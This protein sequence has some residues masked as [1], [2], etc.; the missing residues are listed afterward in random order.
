LTTK[1]S[2]EN[3]IKTRFSNVILDVKVMNNVEFQDSYI[4]YFYNLGLTDPRLESR[5]LFNQVEFSDACSF[6]NVYGFVVPRSISNNLNYLNISQ[7]TAIVDDINEEKI[8]TSAFIP[9]DPVFLLFDIAVPSETMTV[10]NIANTKLVIVKDTISR[11]N[12]SNIKND[13]ESTL[14]SFFSPK[15]NKLGQTLNID[16]LN[17]D[18]L[19]IDGVESFYTMDANTGVQFSGISL[20]S[21]NPIYQDI[22]TTNVTTKITLEDFQF[23]YL[24]NKSFVDRITVL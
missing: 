16:T 5:A 21:W 19:S 13:V 24:Y 9:M 12:E 4:R 10:N 17:N 11:R 3:F 15:N 1:K 18:I 8:L 6:N 14:Q 2:Y 20:I 22:S 7:K 23:P